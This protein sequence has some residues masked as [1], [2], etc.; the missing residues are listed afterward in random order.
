[1]K[2][3]REEIEKN[4]DDLIS[5]RLESRGN[6]DYNTIEKT[7]EDWERVKN[8]YFES[9]YNMEIIPDAERESIKKSMRS[10]K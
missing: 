2:K 10:I 6:N 5:I 8:E 4:L 3:T 9:L 1:M 7:Q